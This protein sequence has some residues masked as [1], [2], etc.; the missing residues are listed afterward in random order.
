MVKMHDIKEMLTLRAKMRSIKYAET[1]TLK[2]SQALT[3]THTYIY[4]CV[5][6]RYQ[7]DEWTENF[8][9]LK[10]CARS[11]TIHSA[12]SLCITLRDD[13]F[14]AKSMADWALS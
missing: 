9:S 13:S 14:L 8:P 7:P 1:L 2:A 10:S 5:S 4:M 6:N 3:H 11:K 12:M